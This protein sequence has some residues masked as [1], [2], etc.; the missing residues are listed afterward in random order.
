[1]V[2]HNHL[3]TEAE[4]GETA[5]VKAAEM[6]VSLVRYDFRYRRMAT[7]GGGWQWDTTEANRWND[8]L[9]PALRWTK[10]HG[11]RTLVNLLAYSPP[12]HSMAELNERWQEHWGTSSTLDTRDAALWAA[13]ADGHGIDVPSPRE[14]TEALIDRL[15]EGQDAGDWDIAGFC[16][17]NEPNTKW[18]GEPNW[19][20]LK[21]GSGEIYSTADYCSDMLGWVKGHI[22]REHGG[23]LSHTV[24]VVNLYSYRGH[25][26]D[27]SWRRVAA[28]PNLDV[29]G[30]D[31]YW[32]HLLGAFAWG[33]PGAMAAIS[34][35]HGKPWW[36]VETAG[37]DGPG[38]LW[39]R[40]SCR[41]I[42]AV[43]DL[44]RT[45]GARVLGYYRLW[46][47]PPGLLDFAGAYNILT[48]PSGEP[49]P[50]TDGRG[51]RYWETIRD[52]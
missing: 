12:A 36:L 21:M 35:E 32:D 7:A 23:T 24:T 17:L 43:S 49:T 18:P 27:R 37:A 48:D 28:S 26:R 19:R 20:R 44:C 14:Y 22:E 39:R 4:G 38:R 29:L 10:E 42:R 51:E 45:N 11:M 50:R 9:A 13:W 34:R 52:L 6:G 8:L 5:F 16:V 2:S 40:P 41:R 15:A 31:I 30:I 33:R 1:M 3:R 25:W 46:G 47:D